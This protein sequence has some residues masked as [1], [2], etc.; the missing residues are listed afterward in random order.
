MAFLEPTQVSEKLEITDADGNTIWIIEIG[1]NNE[2]RIKNT[3]TGKGLFYTED[4][5]EG[6]LSE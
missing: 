6:T 3:N 1:E 2:L 4:C 5:Q